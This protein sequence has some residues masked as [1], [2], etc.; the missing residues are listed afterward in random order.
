MG[1]RTP[2]LGDYLGSTDYY[3][4]GILLLIG[5]FLTNS[6]IVTGASGYCFM[7]PI[8]F[9]LLFSY[10]SHL[11]TSKDALAF[12][13]LLSYLTFS[14]ISSLSLILLR[15][16]FKLEILRECILDLI[17]DVLAF[18]SLPPPLADRV[19]RSERALF[20]R[21]LCCCELELNALPS[22]SRG[23]KFATVANKQ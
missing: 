5:G 3:L 1:P 13:N 2:P 14:C 23:A 18:L 17:F 21:G 6:E 15:S 22:R 10:L 19:D 12:Y 8:N 11:V 9:Y 16:L 7:L 4:L 20:Y